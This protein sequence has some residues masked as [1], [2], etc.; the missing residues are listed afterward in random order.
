MRILVALPVALLLL[1]GC[2]TPEPVVDTPLPLGP[3]LPDGTPAPLS[4]ALTDCSEQIGIFPA[5]ESYAAPYLP[6]G[7]K[8]VPFNQTPYITVV[9]VAYSCATGNVTM[10]SA[11][12]GILVTPP[13]AF[14]N[15]TASLH[16]VPISAYTDRADIA[17]VYHAWGAN[18]THAAADVTITVSTPENPLLR[19]GEVSASGPMGSFTMRTFAPVAGG[20]PEAAGSARVFIV[21]AALNVTGAMDV[22][23][24]ASAM[25]TGMGTAVFDSSASGPAGVPA[26]APGVA[27]HFWGAYDYAVTYVPLASPAAAPAA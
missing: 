22:A 24:T 19:A 7:F 11:D 3:L 16:I 17:D 4:L 26:V 20:E 1:S 23:W 27:F 12:L 25:A 15:A 5:D 10:N 6:A 8:A 2:T 18:A 14:A 9:L 13:T 21:D